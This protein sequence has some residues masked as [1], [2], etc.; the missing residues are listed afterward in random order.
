MM[1]WRTGIIIFHI[2]KLLTAE[3]EFAFFW[4]LSQLL[5]FIFV[6]VFIGGVNFLKNKIYSSWWTSPF[7][8]ELLYKR[9]YYFCLMHLIGALLYIRGIIFL[10]R[11]IFFF[12]LV[13]GFFWLKT[14]SSVSIDSK[15][16]GWADLGIRIFYCLGSLSLRMLPVIGA[17]G[18]S[19]SGIESLTTVL[20]SGADEWLKELNSEALTA[21]NTASYDF[22]KNRFG[23]QSWAHCMAFTFLLFV[24]RSPAGAFTPEN[25][26]MWLRNYNKLLTVDQV[27][28]ILKFSTIKFGGPNISSRHL[29]EKRFGDVLEVFG[30][31]YAV[32]EAANKPGVRLGVSS[33]L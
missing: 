19:E 8:G 22:F 29:L 7:W 12:I 26:S 6:L 17:A 20:Q 11:Y 30:D 10:W 25:L 16:R 13:R 14:V 4:V 28:L 18:G 24:V 15:V 5:F 21:W 27:N 1:I 3:I 33:F 23:R 32:T 31:I 2:I 9:K